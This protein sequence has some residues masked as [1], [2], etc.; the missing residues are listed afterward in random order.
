[1]WICRYPI[2]RMGGAIKGNTNFLY[3]RQIKPFD[4][5]AGR[6]VILM[7]GSV[8]GFT[9]ILA[10][11]FLFTSTRIPENI[12]I[13][14]I[15]FVLVLWYVFNFCILIGAL[16]SFAPFGNHLCILAG[17]AH[18]LTTGGFF[19]VDWLPQ[20]LRGIA[21][22]FPMVHATEMM[23][24]GWFGDVVICYYDTSYVILF[25][26]ALTLFSLLLVRS[27]AW[28]RETYGSPT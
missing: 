15:A 24:D 7:F 23:R 6:T 5:L 1:M 25:N 22:L 28:M 18:I 9:I 4:L 14:L 16:A 11:A 20:S 26:L 27:Y 10:L 17:A 3:H 12:L 2:Q 8:L 21:L 19:M 13:C